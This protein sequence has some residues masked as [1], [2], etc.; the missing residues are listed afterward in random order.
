MGVAILM[1]MFYHTG[2]AFFGDIGVE[3]FFLLSGV[4]LAYSLSKNGNVWHFYRKRFLRIIPTY[5]VVVIP[6]AIFF[7]DKLQTSVIR[8]I[9]Q[10]DTIMGSMGFMAWW[11]IVMIFFLYIIAPFI[12]GLKSHVGIYILIVLSFIFSFCWPEVFPINRIFLYRLPVILI[13][14]PFGILVPQN[15]LFNKNK[16]SVILICAGLSIIAI[17]AKSIFKKDG[18]VDASINA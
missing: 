10:V 8:T 6:T 14:I 2:I 3:L 1:I 5:L 18:L 12:F 15:K 9:F 17:F 11:F 4:G 7:Q 13:A 16:I